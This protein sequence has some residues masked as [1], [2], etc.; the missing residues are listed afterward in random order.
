MST[1]TTT[2]V[3]STTHPL[4]EALDAK[5]GAAN[6]FLQRDQNGKWMVLVLKPRTK[7]SHAWVGPTIEDAMLGV[8][9]AAEKGEGVA[10]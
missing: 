1:T 9:L 6:W 8:L 3:E 10:T 2:S 5:I 7:T 4:V